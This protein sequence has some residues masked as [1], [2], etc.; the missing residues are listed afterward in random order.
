MIFR[1]VVLR[2]VAWKLRE[3]KE[4]KSLIRVILESKFIV[5]D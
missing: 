5:L 2:Y 1:L 3:V 4:L